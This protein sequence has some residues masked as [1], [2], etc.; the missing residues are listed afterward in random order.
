MEKLAALHI[1]DNTFP[2]EVLLE[3]AAEAIEESGTSPAEPMHYEGM[4]RSTSPR[5]PLPRQAASTQEPLC[6]DGRRDDQGRRLP[7][8][9]D[10]AAGWGIEDMW[11]YAFYALLLY[12]RTAAERTRQ[13]PEAIAAAIAR[14]HGIDLEPATGS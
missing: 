1:R 2:A 11:E 9:L 4:P 8:L 6:A 13:P 5:V 10:E 7:D 12:G 14:R 3:L